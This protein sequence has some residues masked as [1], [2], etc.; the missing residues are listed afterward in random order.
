MST[1][2]RPSIPLHSRSEIVEFDWQWTI[3]RLYACLYLLWIFRLIDESKIVCL[4]LW[5]WQRIDAQT[6]NLQ[7]HYLQVSLLF[8]YSIAIMNFK[9][10]NHTGFYPAHQMFQ[11]LCTPIPSVSFW[12]RFLCCCFFSILW[13]IFDLICI[14]AQHSFIWIESFQSIVYKYACNEYTQKYV[15]KQELND[16]KSIIPVLCL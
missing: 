15:C 7:S 3:I 11:Q 12:N 10:Q 14:Y 6:I 5:L 13:A 1:N 2:R 9:H 8:E 4:P 16:M